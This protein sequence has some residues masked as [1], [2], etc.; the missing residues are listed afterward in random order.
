MLH[1]VE[2][3]LSREEIEEI[4]GPS[5]ELAASVRELI[6][7]V[8]RTEVDVEE[9]TDVRRTV[10]ELTARLRV[11]QLPGTFGTRFGNDGALRNWGNAATGLRNAVAPPLDVTYRDDGL[12]VGLTTLNAAY[13]GPATFAHGGVG[14]LLLDQVMG[15]AAHAAGRPGMTANLTLTYHAPTRL[16]PVRAEA[17]ALPVVVGE[18]HK[19]QVV[20]RLYS[21]SG[22]EETL[23]IEA[24]G[25]FILPRAVRERIEREGL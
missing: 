13:E 2:D 23:S 5:A 18:E 17:E 25:L 15:E 3:H 12:V 6:E 9:L 24:T 19:T 20:G 7:A 14:A 10:D 22:D 8:V 1:V 21:L 4:A 16:G 11:R